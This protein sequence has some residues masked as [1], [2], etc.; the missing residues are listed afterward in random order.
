LFRSVANYQMKRL[1][2]DCL[3]DKLNG[4]AADKPKV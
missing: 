3:A 1:L 2:Y 4:A